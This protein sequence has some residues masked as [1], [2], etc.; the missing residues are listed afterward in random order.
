MKAMSTTNSLVVGR[1][2]SPVPIQNVTIRDPFWSPKLKTWREV[3]LLD[4]FRKFENEGAFENFNRVRDGLTGGHK[5]RPWYDGLVYE[6]IQGAADFLAVKRDAKLEEYLDALI[7][8]ISAAAAKDPDGYLNTYTQLEKPDQRWGLNGGDPV[9]QHDL[10]NAGAMVEAAVHYARATG[11]TKLLG[12][13]VRFANHI[14]SFIGPAPKTNMVPEHAL[15]EEAF[16]KLYELFVEQPD[17]KSVM[18]VPI[19]EIRYLKLVEFWI[20]NRGR[21]EGRKSFGAY[22]QDHLP[23]LEQPTIEGHAVRAVLLCAGMVAAAR[24]NGRKDYLETAERLWRNMVERRLHVTGS[25]GAYAE[26]EKFGGDYALPHDAYLETCAAIGAA[27]FHR[28]MNLALGQAKNVDE[29]ERA[30]FNGVISGVSLAGDTYF[31]ENPLEAGPERRRWEWHSCPCCPPMFAKIVGALPGY[32]YAMD[33]QGIYVNLF[34]SSTARVQIGG[35]EIVVALKTRYPWRGDVRISLTPAKPALFAVNIRIPGWSAGATL[36]VNGRK[37]EQPQIVNGY[38]RIEREW[39]AGDSVEV[40]IP[41]PAQLVRC[42]PL[43]EAN[44]ARNAIVRG[45]VVY[46]LEGVDNEGPVTQLKIPANAKLAVKYKPDMLGG[47]ATVQAKGMRY[48]EEPWG[49]ALYRPRVG[50]TTTQPVV[51]TAIPYYAN[52]NR[53]ATDMTVWIPE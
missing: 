37:I 21:Y 46:C 35:T 29:F 7:E 16:V 47:V 14:V 38:A 26:E 11:K 12:T 1:Q 44:R 22:S 15:P 4:S 3:T 18:P 2:L 24:R 48:E 13:A 19:D 53:E 20:E 42:N 31:Y 50:P 32:V 40:S 43:A 36:S 5:G 8:R 51:V 9:Y 41:M 49:D 52:S 25:V 45:P 39:A 30:L 6:M 23:V 27:F 28:N 33:A 10:Y 34:V 17:L